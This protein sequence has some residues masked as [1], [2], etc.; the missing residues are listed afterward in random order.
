[1]NF[2]NCVLK[3]TKIMEMRGNTN[4]SIKA[5]R[6]C[7]MKFLNTVNKPVDSITSRDVEDYL[8]NLINKGYANTTV[9][10]N[11]YILSF[12]FSQIM[13]K[14]EITHPLHYMKK[15]KRLPDILSKDEIESI[16][17][18]SGTLKNKVIFMTIYSSGL[19][20]S[21]LVNL[22]VSDIDSK[23]M[24][25]RIR[26]GKGQKDRFTILSERTL[27][28]L[29]EY[30]KIYRPEDWLF[31]PWRHK[32]EHLSKRAVQTH[33]KSTVAAA[34]IAKSITPHSLR[35]AFASHLLECGTDIY[36]IKNLLG[37]SSLQSTQV[38]LQLSPSR[39]LSV[40]SP[41]DQR[42]AE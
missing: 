7:L 22:K 5:Y 35:H 26:Q 16:F 38:Y 10:H 15:P 39:V 4:G 21:E 14:P 40:K 25:L 13:N 37:H 42:F 12:F 3:M 34:G 29:R 32:S 17:E 6:F 8:Y 24:Q 30:Y 31:Y 33:L 36:S 23:K 41:L 28:C 2:E 18:A 19:R 20:V 9:N 11:H 1:M 27:Y